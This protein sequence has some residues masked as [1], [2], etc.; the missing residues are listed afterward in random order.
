MRQKIDLVV[1][2]ASASTT[3][4]I[5]PNYKTCKKSIRIALLRETHER[6][7]IRPVG[8]SYFISAKLDN[9]ANIEFRASNLS[10]HPVRSATW[11]VP[12]DQYDELWEEMEEDE[13]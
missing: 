10:N 4:T 5:Y 9:E 6:L 1:I 12:K 7:I 11:I 13:D 2:H 3:Y 8:N